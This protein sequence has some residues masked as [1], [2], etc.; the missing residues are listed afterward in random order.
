MSSL[1]LLMVLILCNSL[2][3]SFPLN[4]THRRDKKLSHTLRVSTLQNEPFVK[5]NNYGDLSKG[6]EFELIK[7]ITEKENLKLLT[8]NPLQ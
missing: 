3:L 6:I 1:N 7:I 2:V 8:K 4:N 5:R